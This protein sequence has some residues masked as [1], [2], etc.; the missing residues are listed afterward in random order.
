MFRSTLGLAAMLLGLFVGAPMS[1]AQDKPQYGGHLRVGLDPEP[2]SLDP[3]AGRSGFD[4]YY[5][6]QI[7]DQL[8]DADQAGAPDPTTSLATTWEI[9][10]NPNAITFTLRE[11]VKFHDGT[12]F[13]ADAVKKNIE[14]ILDPATK[15]TPACRLA[16]ISSVEVLEIYKVRFNLSAPWASG[17]GLSG[18]SRRSD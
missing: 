10:E 4:A 7:F 6:R 16:I 12:P 11:G 18:G 15:A 5:Y 17:L 3:I 9:S 13:D 2:T 1:A 14:R 8:V